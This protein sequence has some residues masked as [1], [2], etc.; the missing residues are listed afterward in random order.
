HTYNGVNVSVHQLS[1][2]VAA[3]A[4]KLTV[5]VDGGIRNGVDVFRALALGADGVM[6]GRPWIFAIAA[7]GEA[8]LVQLL[9][10]WQKELRL[11]MMLA[12]VTRIEDINGEHRASYANKKGRGR[13]LVSA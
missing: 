11:A 9:Q 6:I 2:I 12:G 4:G 13:G 7:A 10:T 5:L 3:V 1:D 8:G